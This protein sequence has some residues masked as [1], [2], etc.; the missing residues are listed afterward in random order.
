MQNLDPRA[1]RGLEET[2]MRIGGWRCH[3]ACDTIRTMHARAVHSSRIMP[4]AASASAIESLFVDECDRDVTR[5]AVPALQ[6]VVRYGRSVPSGLDVHAMGAR[7][8]AH[9]KLIRRG[10]RSVVARL[11]L[12]A[13]EAVFGVPACAIAGRIVALADLWGDEATGRLVD[14]LASARESVDAAIIGSARS[15]S[16][17]RART[18]CTPEH[19]LRSRRR[20]GSR[21]RACG[22]SRESSR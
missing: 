1:A 18:G 11:R 12:G 10:Q 8:T 2:D 5:V 19:A 14:R 4:S 17:L 15:Q 13:H 21:A 20:S 22:R 16:A 3:R 9:R 6:L 7:Q